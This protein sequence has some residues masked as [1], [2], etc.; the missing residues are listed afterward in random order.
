MSLADI[1]RRL[2]AAGFDVGAPDGV[3]GRHTEAAI[4]ALLDAYGVLRADMAPGTVPAAWMPSASMQRIIVHWTAGGYGASSL[5]RQHYHILI[6]SDGRLARGNPS[7]DLNESPVRPGYAAHTLN[8]NGGSIGVSCCSMAGAVESPFDAGSF[9]LTTDQ[10]DTLALV[11]ADLCLRYDIPVGAKTLLS[12]AEVHDTL[13]IHQLG[14]W[15]IAR[16]PFD[17]SLV[18]AHV[19]GDRLRAKVAAHIGG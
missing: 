1:Q 14:K 6:E 2:D 12:H 7:I 11:C 16:L 13:G 3:Y 10:W 5:D 15:D 19:V 9:P 4:A 17:P 18:G 8:C